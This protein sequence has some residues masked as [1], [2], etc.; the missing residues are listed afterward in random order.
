[1]QKIVVVLLLWL[2]NSSG[3][4]TQNADWARMVSSF[5]ETY[6]ALNVSQLRISYADNMNAIQPAE[7][8]AQQESAFRKLRN[9][10]EGTQREKLTDQQQVE[11]DLLWYQL[12]LN[13]ERIGLEKSWWE[14][15][16][17]E[18]PSEGLSQLPNGQAWYRYFLKRWLDTAVTPEELY[19]FGMA[20]VEK[21]LSEM[22]TIQE[23][24][25]MDS[26]AFQAYI[27]SDVFF[28]TSQA[29][30]QEAFEAFDHKIKKH[31]SAYFPRMDE[32]PPIRIELSTDERLA[33]VPG[34]YRNNTFYYNFFGSS[35]NKR[36]VRWFYLHE[37]VP[38]HHYEVSYHWA[39]TRS[40]LQALFNNPGFSEG[41]AAYVEE[42]GN[43]IGA[44]E[45]P[46][47]ELGKWEWD[48]IRSVRVPLDIGLNYHGWSDEQALVF[49]Q[50]YIVGQDEIALREIARMRRWPCQV[51]TYKYGGDKILGWKKE[52]AQ[53]P[54]FNLKQFHTQV[55]QYGRLPFS[56][57]EKRLMGSNNKS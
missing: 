19:D 55:L 17:E 51:I 53:N 44:Y 40:P 15:P 22:K 52:L 10:L 30:V 28:F 3:A 14:N 8:L 41:W 23:Q 6:E 31:L 29:Q 13:E 21:V 38:G 4:C 16:L 11:Y 45:G 24:S 54:D 50:Q 56:L 36:Q 1:M 20:E 49:W 25:G 37:A 35:F 33:Q 47:D 26:L 46:Y 27:N 12:L 34:F 48:I 7:G 43:E 18:L 32:I 42:I 9:D 2:A 57:L 5:E 39:H